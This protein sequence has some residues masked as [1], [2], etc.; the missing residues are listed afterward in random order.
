M[1]WRFASIQSRSRADVVK[2]DLEQLSLAPV[3]KRIPT[4]GFLFFGGGES[5]FRAVSEQSLVRF[6]GRTSGSLSL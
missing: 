4:F 2:G 6:C 1:V 3:E 5:R